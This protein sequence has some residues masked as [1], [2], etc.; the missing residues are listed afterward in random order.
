[1]KITLN[2]EV[3]NQAKKNGTYPIYLRA[4][5]HGHHFKLALDVYVTNRKNFIVQ[6][7]KDN[8]INEQY[9]HSIE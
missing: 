2:F 8:W 9:K 4:T 7:K 1:M 5:E 3:A 6:A